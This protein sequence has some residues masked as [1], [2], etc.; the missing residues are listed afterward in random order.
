MSSIYKSVA[1]AFLLACGTLPAS[2]FT[3]SNINTQSFQLTAKVDTT[4]TPIT[5]YVW[6]EQLDGIDSF[7]MSMHS[8]PSSTN[9]DPAFTSVTTYLYLSDGTVASAIGQYDNELVSTIP[10]ALTCTASTNFECT[11][12][13]SLTNK[14]G[15]NLTYHHVSLNARAGY[16]QTTVN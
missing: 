15:R 4:C 9:G 8:C 14:A 7:E 13:F 16:T 1:L 6:K 3:T 2:A 10:P 5:K 12:W 11:A